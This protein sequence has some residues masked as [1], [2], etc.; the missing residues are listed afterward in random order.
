MLGI[1]QFAW[2]RQ[3]KFTVAINPGTQNEHEKFFALDNISSAAGST[4]TVVQQ[5]H[6]YRLARNLE[7]RRTHLD[8][9]WVKRMDFQVMGI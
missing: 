2:I 7:A 6:C 5:Q 4:L 1:L 9:N 3:S 8:W